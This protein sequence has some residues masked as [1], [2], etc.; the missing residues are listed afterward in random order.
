MFLPALTRDLFFSVYLPL[1]RELDD[2]EGGFCSQLSWILKSPFRKKLI[3]KTVLTLSSDKG[4][5]TI[6]LGHEEVEAISGN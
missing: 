1:L 5:F 2:L 4:K 6:I 3:I